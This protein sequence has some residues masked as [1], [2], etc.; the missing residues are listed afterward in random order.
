MNVNQS[1][2]L[3]SQPGK[4]ITR[5]ALLI[6][7]TL[8][9]AGCSLDIIRLTAVPFL[10][11]IVAPP[12]SV[13]TIEQPITEIPLDGPLVDRRAQF[14][15]LGWYGD[16]LILL[17]QFPNVWED[18]IFTLA[19]TDIVDFLTGRRSQPLLPQPIPVLNGDLTWQIP[20]FEGFES[21]AFEG[22]RVFLTI[23]ADRGDGMMGYL[24][25]GV[26]APDLSELRLDPTRLAEI[27]PQAALRNISDE[28]IFLA[29][30]ALI[31]LYEANSLFVNSAPVAHRFDRD[32]NPLGTLP[33]VNF[34]YRLT[35][36]TALDA[37]NRF[38][39]INYF[40]PGDAY[41][42][43]RIGDVVGGN[44]AIPEKPVEQLVELQFSAEGITLAGTPSIALQ[45]LDENIARNWEGIVRLE[46]AELSGFLLVTDYY[47]ETILAFVPK[48][49]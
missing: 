1:S 13:Q 30:D 49:Q 18:Q 42:Q 37:D 19:K 5:L 28:A 11:T 47:P 45:L 41:L 40:F 6:A 39:V 29:G 31:T 12:T 36:A 17:P 16:N 15:G 25:A 14:S 9:L 22:D 34:P 43:R 3:F 48:P 26:M 24:I 8:L 44:A 10:R 7:L 23:E 4:S 46:T 21:I 27:Q 35:D 20:G 2:T 33:F 32:L 38:W